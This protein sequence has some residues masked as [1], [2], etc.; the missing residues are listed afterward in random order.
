M[1][2]VRIDGDGWV[3]NDNIKEVRPFLNCWV[4]YK[5]KP[6]VRHKFLQLVV[7]FGI[8]NHGVIDLQEYQSG[9]DT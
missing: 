9:I 8:K 3:R 1:K 7:Y 4:E 5:F 2:Q 6:C